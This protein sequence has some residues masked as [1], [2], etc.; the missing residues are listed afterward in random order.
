[1]SPPDR[2]KG[3]DRSAQHEGSPNGALGEAQARRARPRAIAGGR[4]LGGSRT[5]AGAEAEP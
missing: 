5:K 2:P 3:E 4:P 1:M